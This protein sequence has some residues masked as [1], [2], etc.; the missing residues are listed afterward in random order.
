MACSFI[1]IVIDLNYFKTLTNGAG[2]GGGAEGGGRVFMPL[3]ALALVALTLAQGI[4]KSFKFLT[5]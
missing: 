5:S 1:I 4:L 3:Q 2:G